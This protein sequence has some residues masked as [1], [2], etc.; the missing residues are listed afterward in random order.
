MKG[1]ALKN[2]KR[3]RSL[4]QL[5]ER[6]RESFEDAEDIQARGI[7]ELEER[8]T[9]F[10]RETS[11]RLGV[12]PS[13]HNRLENLESERIER[14]IA[15]QAEDSEPPLNGTGT[16]RLLNEAQRHGGL[17]AVDEEAD[18]LRDLSIQIHA[19][20]DDRAHRMYR[21]ILADVEDKV[22]SEAVGR[23]RSLLENKFRAMH[24][25][26]VVSFDTNEICRAVR[27][28]N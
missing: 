3:I 8:F 26:R 14:V 24:T 9:H 7:A 10:A 19:L 28:K 16:D 20:I 22:L 12:V 27:G 17:F 23:V 15:G 2:S 18:P 21:S 1:K 25:G 4:E 5:V 6:M 11:N 13:L